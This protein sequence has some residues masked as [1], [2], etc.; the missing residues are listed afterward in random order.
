[1]ATS[2]HRPTVP[3]PPADLAKIK[4]PA[5]TTGEMVWY[6][7]NDAT[8][9]N[10]LFYSRTGRYRF[11]SPPPTKWGVS[12]WGSSIVGCMQEIWG[13]AAR[14]RRGIDYGDIARMD[15]WEL[16]IPDRAFVYVELHGAGL[17]LIKAHMGCFTG[18][19]KKSQKWGAAL[20]DH[21]AN[22]D[23]VEYL[24]RRCGSPCLA[25]FGD[26]NPAKGKAYQAK[27]IRKKLGPLVNWGKFWTTRNDL[28]LRLFNI[29]A[30]MPPKTF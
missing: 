29:P 20:M 7:L 5:H 8:H 27:L 9:P 30:T 1:M 3:D 24:G 22:L 10:P 17:T 25:M 12:Y 16:T 13:D 4:L 11:D 19:Y 6:R 14:N 18:G 21:P 26:Q 2:G 23:G 28:G 15:V